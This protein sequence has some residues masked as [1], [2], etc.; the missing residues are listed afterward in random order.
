MK[1]VSDEVPRFNESKDNIAHCEDHATGNK[2]KFKW[3]HYLRNL[4]GT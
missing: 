1:E 2:N 4:R 3:F